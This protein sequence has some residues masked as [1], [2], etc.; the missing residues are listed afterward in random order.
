[1]CRITGHSARVKCCDLSSYLQLTNKNP[2]NYRQQHETY[3]HMISIL[4]SVQNPSVAQVID[5]C[6]TN[7]LMA[8]A[9]STL[10]HN[11]RSTQIRPIE[12]QY[13]ATGKCGCI[14]ATELDKT[15]KLSCTQR[16]RH[17]EHR[18]QAKQLYA[19]RGIPIAWDHHC[20]PIQSQIILAETQGDQMSEVKVSHH[21]TFS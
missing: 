5:N 18:H 19:K 4:A 7:L 20:A 13:H 12:W 3:S 21:W 6:G 1:M 8:T 9:A 14:F 16:S 11:Q 15:Y 2:A 17:A 10:A